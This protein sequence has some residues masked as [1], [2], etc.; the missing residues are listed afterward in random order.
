MLDPLRA[1]E[2]TAAEVVVGLA[3]E[4]DPGPASEAALALQA[5]LR[6]AFPGKRSLAVVLSASAAGTLEP[7]SPLVPAGEGRPAPAVHAG[8]GPESALHALLEVAHDM[9]APACA[10]LEPMPRPADSDWLRLLFEPVLSGQADLVAPSYQRRRFDGVL[11][12]GLVY[13]LTR[14][15]FAQRIRQ[16]LGTEMVLSRRLVEHLSVDDGWRTDPAHAGSELWVIAKAL[17]R[18][19]RCAQVFLGPRPVPQAQPADVADALAKVLGTLFHEMDLHAARWQR[20][21]GSCPVA[22]YGDEHLPGETAPAPAPGPLVA[23]FELGWRD[24]RN[25]WSVVLPPNTLL[26]LQRIARDPPQAFRM[27]DPIWARVVYDFAVAWRVKVMDRLQLLRSLTP[28]YMGW[29]ASFVND[30]GEL[31]RIRTEDRIERLCLAFEA[32]KPYLISR[33]RWP[34]RF[35]P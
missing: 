2:A 10:L 20:A 7:G 35:M 22:T 23:A 25:L 5:A 4:G 16:P 15:L 8:S 27:P 26:A 17:V 21:R 9:R 31:D 18:E 12:S 24:L 19:C 13:P 34:D 14:A 32:E 33:W 29:L 30:V 6:R 11:V 3:S 1:A 28:I